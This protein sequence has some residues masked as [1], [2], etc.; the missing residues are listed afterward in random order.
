MFHLGSS[1]LQ[2]LVVVSEIA[3]VSLSYGLNHQPRYRSHIQT[4]TKENKASS[5]RCNQCL[6][7]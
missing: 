5:I 1:H 2:R 7:H 4:Y 6:S 3:F